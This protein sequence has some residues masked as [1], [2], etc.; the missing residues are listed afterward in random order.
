TVCR[1]FYIVRFVTPRI[2]RRSVL[3]LVAALPLAACGRSAP[4]QGSGRKIAPGSS[5][6]LLVEAD[7]TLS[8]WSSSVVPN[9]Y[10]EFGLGH[11]KLVK[12]FARIPIPALT[13]VV[14]AGAGL[15]CSYA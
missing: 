10:G 9:L 12:R 2:T 11:N 7:G 14:A 3:S 8:G 1:R 13:G 15:D 5:H 4:R 6:T